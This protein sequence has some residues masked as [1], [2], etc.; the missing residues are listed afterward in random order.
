M[1][2]MDQAE[3]VD[4]LT[5]LGSLIQQHGARTVALDFWKFYPSEA[6]ALTASLIQTQ[7]TKK[8]PRLLDKDANTG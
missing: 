2:D 8:L 5:D 3:F 1:N 4:V 6:Q 7:H